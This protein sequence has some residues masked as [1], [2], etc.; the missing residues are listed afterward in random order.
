MPFSGGKKEMR[1][2]SVTVISLGTGDPELLNGRTIRTIRE[3][4]SLVLRTG[5]HQIVS[6]LEQQ[7][8]PFTTLDHLYDQAEDFSMLNQN[9]CDH[10]QVLA[11]VSPVVYAVTD[12][13]SDRT[14]R[15]L[16]SGDKINVT[17][18]PGTGL[19]DIHLSAALSTLSESPVLT[20]P[21]YDL[22]S[23]YPYD[24]N[25]SLLITELNDSILAG[26]VKIFLSET[27][28]DMHTIYLIHGVSAPE[29]SPLYKLDRQRN[30]DHMTAVLVPACGYT[31][32][33]R[34]VFNDLVSLME[35]LRAPDGCPWDRAQTHLSL[36][37]Y[38][39][40]EAW[41]CVASIDQEDPDH[42]CEEL[43]DLLFQVVFHS[44]VG[45]AFDEFTINDVITAI[46]GKMIRR[47]PHV[48]S[49]Q[50]LPDA[51]CVKDA[52]EKIKQRETGS[53]TISDSLDDV[54]SG[55]PSLK[56]AAKV[57]RKLKQAPAG[58]RPAAQILS[59]L[60]SLADSFL[61]GS[62]PADE[63]GLG[64]LLLLCAEYCSHSG[65][66]SELVLHRSVDHLKER[67]KTVEKALIRD[68]KSLEHL[69]FDEVRVYLKH[70]ED[71]IE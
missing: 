25:H 16:L 69:T 48:F 34:F 56:Y 14:V 40:E 70:V 68:G 19:F 10:L 50:S 22:L 15:F 38:M 43:G 27:L 32:R 6:W 2:A 36:R 49:T 61:S 46:T 58:N 24:P 62:V 13:V 45:K 54:S 18:V 41:E 71:E 65:I 57:F 52:W 67:L 9:I 30:I 28:D 23:G 8:I 29:S 3:A 5:R 47:H 17:V 59:D 55:L 63:D 42:L 53:A 64:R 60:R 39:V 33:Q 21:A 4:P 12:A 11:S 44:S 66:D 20:A 35:K 31:E 51:E 37:P 1:K 7:H 26:Q